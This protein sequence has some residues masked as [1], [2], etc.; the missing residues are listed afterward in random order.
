MFVVAILVNVGMWL[1]R[2]VI[3]VISLHRDFVPSS[4]AMYYPKWV[5]IG[6]FTGTLLFFFT[7]MLLFFKFLPTVAASE[8]KELNY[9]LQE[10]EASVTGGIAP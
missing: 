2:F 8:V 1:E 6:T 7:N 4:W 5:D 10:P 3:I 9:E